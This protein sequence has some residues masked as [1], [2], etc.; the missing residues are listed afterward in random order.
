MIL[1]KAKRRARTEIS[2][3]YLDNDDK[4]K[5]VFNTKSWKNKSSMIL[6]L[7]YAKQSIA[8]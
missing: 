7:Y 4:N 5:A 3:I 6:R 1:K 2:R 8:I